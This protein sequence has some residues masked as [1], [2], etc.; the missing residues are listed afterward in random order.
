MSAIN[1]A[2]EEKIINGFVWNGKAVYL[3][4]ENQLN[5][6]AIERSEKI[7]YPLILKINEQEDGT[8]IY[9][10][11]ENADDFIAF[12]QAACAYVIK[13]VQEGWKEKDEVDWTVFNL[14]SNNDEKVD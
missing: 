4:P 14:K 6:S 5:F 7:P 11:F 12:S 8:P 9:H 3:S 2:T 13:T 10:T 1:T